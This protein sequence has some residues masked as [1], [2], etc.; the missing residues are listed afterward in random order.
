MLTPSCRSFRLY[1][2]FAHVVY[3]AIA[4]LDQFE[5]DLLGFL[6]RRRSGPNSFEQDGIYNV[7]GKSIQWLGLLFATF[8]SGAQFSVRPKKERDPIAQV[9]GDICLLFDATLA[10][11][12]TSLLLI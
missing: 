2:D 3:P 8:A 9:Y 1:R 4:E 7:H 6:T 5:S 12:L 10:D 11:F